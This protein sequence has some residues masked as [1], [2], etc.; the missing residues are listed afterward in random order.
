MGGNDGAN[1]A[2]DYFDEQGMQVTHYVHNAQPV[3][4]NFLQR[5]GL[6]KK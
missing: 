4:A 6:L 3:D 5:A 2:I 1:S